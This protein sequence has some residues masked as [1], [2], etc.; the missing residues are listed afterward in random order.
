MNDS[1]NEQMATKRA[2]LATLLGTMGQSESARAEFLVALRQGEAEGAEKFLNTLLAGAPM[3]AA[4]D[5]G[6][7]LHELLRRGRISSAPPWSVLHA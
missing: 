2:E 5:Q 6:Q 4:V 7:T 1:M 3:L